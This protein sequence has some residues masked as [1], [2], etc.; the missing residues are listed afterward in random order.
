M[1]ATTAVYVLPTHLNHEHPAITA[2][3]TAAYFERETGMEAAM[4]FARAACRH[5]TDDTLTEVVTELVELANKIDTLDQSDPADALYG[6]G[7]FVE[8]GTTCEQMA[9]QLRG[10]AK[11]DMMLAAHLAVSNDEALARRSRLAVAS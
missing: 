8:R 5:L 1:T 6:L 3:M 11:A 10:E 7:Y 2:L 4:R 9:D